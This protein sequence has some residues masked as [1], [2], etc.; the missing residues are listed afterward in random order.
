MEVTRQAP[1]KEQVIAFWAFMTEKYHI[2]VREKATSRFMK[3]CA[4]LLDALGIMDQT[5]F[6]ERY[7]TKIGDYLWIVC[8]VGEGDAEERAH[9]IS[10]I[11]HECGHAIQRQRWTPFFF[12]LFYLISREF[13]ASREIEAYCINMYLF[14]WYTEEHLNVHRL[15]NKLYGYGCKKKQVTR[16]YETFLD[17]MTNIEF[18]ITRLEIKEAIEDTMRYFEE[19]A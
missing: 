11:A 6:M 7:H 16:A 18:N 2:K 19:A 10:S 5:K 3:I 12:S 1:T 14:Y 9:Q 8:D 13:R 4:V 15:A 17:E